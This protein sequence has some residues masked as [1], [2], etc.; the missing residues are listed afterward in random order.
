MNEKNQD[1]L[2]E[3]LEFLDSVSKDFSIPRNVRNVSQEVKEYLT[4]PNEPDLHVKR[5][6]AISRLEEVVDDPNVP[7]HG[8]TV[9]WD[10]LGRI[11]SL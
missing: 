8:R 9:L 3:L 7:I 6:Q 11:E 10:I 5:N 2:K 4:D 1:N